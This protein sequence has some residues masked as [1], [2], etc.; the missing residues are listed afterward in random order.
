MIPFLALL[1]DRLLGEPPSRLHPVVWMGTLL[2]RLTDPLRGRPPAVAFLGG[3]AAVAAGAF[4]CWAAGRV[5]EGRLSGL[6][7]LA[8]Q[9]AALKTA[10]SVRALDR[11]AGEVEGALCAGDLEAARQAL[12]RHLVSRPTAGLPASSCAAA[13]VESVAE[14]LNDSLVAPLFFY[15]LGGLGGA[16]AYRFLDTADSMLGYRDPEHEWLG[17]AAARLEDA[18][19]WLPAR[20]AA[21]LIALSAIPAGEDARGALRIWRRDGGLTASPNA[22][23]PMAAMAGALGVELEKAGHYRLGRGLRRPE[24]GD[25]R[26]ARRLLRTAALAAALAGLWWWRRRATWP[27]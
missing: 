11:A 20:L 17:K 23:R 24:A 9:A 7:A 27:S 5:L 13:A 4:A 2:S 18:A 1:L 14:N 12:S 8:L 6:P 16:L 19:A 25:L 22:G 26:R 21:A 3:G 15:R 10:L